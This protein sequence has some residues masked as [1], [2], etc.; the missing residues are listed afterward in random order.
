MA[1]VDCSTAETWGKGASIWGVL[2]EREKEAPPKD[3]SS[4]GHLSGVDNSMWS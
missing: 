3:L 2:C 4:L 1:T